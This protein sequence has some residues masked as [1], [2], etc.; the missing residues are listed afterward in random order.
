[1]RYIPPSVLQKLSPDARAAHALLERVSASGA[2]EGS[3]SC[4]EV[5]EGIEKYI[6]HKLAEDTAWL[7]EQERLAG[8]R[9]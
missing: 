6:D 2:E 7:V 1:M 4:T 8:S 5:R 9:L 3:I